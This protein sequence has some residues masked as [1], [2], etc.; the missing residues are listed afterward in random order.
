LISVMQMKPDQLAMS[1]STEQGTPTVLRMSV[2]GE[3]DQAS[4][5]QLRAALAEAA[6]C[7]P[8]LLE[9]DLADVTFCSSA[10]LAELCVARD[11]LDGRLVVTGVRRPVRRLLE[12]LNLQP[13]MAA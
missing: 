7:R 6:A 13:L 11:L 12:V 10:G 2:A 5:P 4:T 3:I 8:A 9:L 1:L